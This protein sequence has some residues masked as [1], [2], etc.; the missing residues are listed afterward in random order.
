MPYVFCTFK[1]YNIGWAKV[2]V[3]LIAFLHLWLKFWDG[4]DKYCIVPVRKLFYFHHWST[5]HCTKGVPCMCACAQIWS[6]DL[7][8]VE[9]S[10]ACGPCFAVLLP[11]HRQSF[12]ADNQKP[13]VNKDLCTR[14]PVKQTLKRAR[15]D[16]LHQLGILKYQVA[17]QKTE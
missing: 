12:S 4:I 16:T 7:A 3:L 13:H 2:D 17:S 5:C 15:A 1:M 10:L 11:C 8:T 14:K 6:A 9:F